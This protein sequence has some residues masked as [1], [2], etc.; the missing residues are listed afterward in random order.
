MIGKRNPADRGCLRRVAEIFFPH[1]MVD[2]C[3]TV[4]NSGWQP[5]ARMCGTDR[6]NH[7]RGTVTASNLYIKNQ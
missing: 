7:T 5:A 2:G 4:L 6:P 3:N 1:G